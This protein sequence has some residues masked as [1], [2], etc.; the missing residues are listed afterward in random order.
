M[1]QRYSRA[2]W[3]RLIDEQGVSGLT[4]RAFCA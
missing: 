1:K 2:D 4:Q 3:Q